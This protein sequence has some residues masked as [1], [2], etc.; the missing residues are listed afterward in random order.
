MAVP[1]LHLPFE[2]IDAFSFISSI[3]KR[4]SPDVIVCMGDMEDWHGINMHDHDPDGLS[5][6][7]ELM[8]LRRRLKP[9][10]KLMP[11]L[12]ICVSNHG[13]LPFRQ[14]FKCGLPKELI[15]SYRDIIEA[16]MGWEWAD[17]W[18]IDGV[19]YEHGDPFS[20]ASAAIK[21]AEQNMQSTVIGHVHSFAGIQ[22]SAN[23]RHLIF[24]FNTGCLIDKDKYAFAYAKKNKRKPILGCGVVIDGVPMFIPMLLNSRGRWIGKLV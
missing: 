4:Y 19:I 23:S 17:A 20:G 3:V 24:G 22:Y 18:E 14:A 7:H 9:Y 5:A 6:G 21:C 10:F 16:P 12:K 11:K 13:S 1:D 15:K 2:H 8:E